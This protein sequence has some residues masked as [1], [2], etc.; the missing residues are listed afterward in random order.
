VKYSTA[1]NV[2]MIKK[3]ERIMWEIWKQRIQLLISMDE[4]LVAYEDGVEV[5]D[6]NWK[7][8]ESALRAFELPDENVMFSLVDK[9]RG[10]DGTSEDFFELRKYFARFF[11]A[12]ALAGANSSTISED[13]RS[14]K[15][16]SD[17]EFLHYN[18]NKKCFDTGYRSRDI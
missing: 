9:L 5:S 12:Q 10:G 7:D 2:R 4:L 3:K 18:H 11:D 6:G 17:R 13:Y 8:M 15:Y 14:C 1:Y 16:G